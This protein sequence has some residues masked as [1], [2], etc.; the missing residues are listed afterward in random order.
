METGCQNLSFKAKGGGKDHQ[1]KCVGSVTVAALTNI[2]L[3]VT[4][5]INVRVEC[6]P[7]IN[8]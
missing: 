5:V 8:D 6:W 3:K 7:Q 4:S 1:R 2:V